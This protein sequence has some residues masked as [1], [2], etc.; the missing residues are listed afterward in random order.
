MEFKDEGQ[1]RN[2]KHETNPFCVD[3][4]GIELYGVTSHADINEQA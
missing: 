4:A 2:I 1:S 3:N